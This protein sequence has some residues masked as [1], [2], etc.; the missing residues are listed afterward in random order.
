MS[1]PRTRPIQKLA[2]AVAKCNTEAA[3][4]GRCVI[5]DY[6]DVHRDKCAKAFMALKNCVVVASKKK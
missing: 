2:A 4:Y 1:Q 6:N 3:A 5:E